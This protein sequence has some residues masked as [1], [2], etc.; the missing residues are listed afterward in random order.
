MDVEPLSDATE[1]AGDEDASSIGDGDGE[2]DPVEDELPGE[3]EAPTTSTF[4][5]PNA[6]PRLRRQKIP[7]L[8]QLVF[9]LLQLGSLLLPPRPH[10]LA[11]DPPQLGL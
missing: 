9:L 5:C 10:P 6:L 1:E 11:G 2:D 7:A 8:L 3:F 4:F